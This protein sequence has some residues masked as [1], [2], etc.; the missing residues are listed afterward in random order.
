MTKEAKIREMLNLQDRLN[1]ITNG[2]E[3]RKGITKE[4]REI[5]WV[6]C[7]YMETAELVDSF[8]WKHWKSL[9]KKDDIENAKVEIIDI[10]HFIM[11]LL[12]SKMSKE[13]AAKLIY[14]ESIIKR[15]YI[16]DKTELDLAELFLSQTVY[17]KD[18]LLDHLVHRFF[19][20]AAKLD[21]DLDTLYEKYII[22]NVLNI[23]RQD[24]GYKDDTYKK[25]LN[26]EEDNVIMYRLAEELKNKGQ[27][28]F[29]NLY[30][31]YEKI[32]EELS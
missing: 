19:Y 6:R 10:W 15:W 20:L 1:I 28:T 32:Y 9:D 14:H 18:K 11:S 31:G 16:E 30:N 5:N 4:G 25:H 23:F 17:H 8:N 27:L 3:W 24:H 13:E 7:I 12:M 21:I 29:D 26:G 22:K 2:E